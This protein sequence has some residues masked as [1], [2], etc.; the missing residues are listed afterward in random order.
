MVIQKAVNNLKEGPKEDK[1]AVASGIAISVVV[2]LLV[3]WAIFFFRGL[4]K[5]SQNVQL[6]GLQDQFNPSSFEA[7][8]SQGSVQMQTSGQQPDQ[9]GTPS[10][11]N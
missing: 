5:D 10:E 3:A 2:V 11:S 1:V 8:Q 4:A 9:F 6:G 7:G